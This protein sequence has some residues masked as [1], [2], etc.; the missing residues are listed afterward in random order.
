MAELGHRHGVCT[1]KKFV[2]IVIIHFTQSW[3]SSRIFQTLSC[4][5]LYSLKSGTLTECLYHEYV[6]QNNFQILWEVQNQWQYKVKVVQWMDLA[7]GWIKL[8]R[9]LLPT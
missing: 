4:Q 5:N 2:I 6:V 9:G 3:F 1:T 7:W 8:A